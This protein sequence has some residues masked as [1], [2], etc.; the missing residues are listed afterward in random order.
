M[1]NPAVFIDRDGVIN[2]DHGYI[3]K[4]DDFEYI[5]GV[6][7]A[8][9]A[10][11]EMG[12]LL[13]LVTNQSGIARGYYTE[14]DFLTLTEWMDWNFADNGVDFDGIY[15]C[16]HHPEHGDETY[17]K[18]CDCRKPKPGMLLDASQFLKIDMDKSVMIGDKA[19]DMRAAEAAGVATKI[20]VRTGKQVSEEGE[21][22]ATAV[23]NSIA[24]VP[25]Y[26]KEM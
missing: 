11:K 6:F 4:V 21:A 5:D 20:L 19:D 1:A 12:Y 9:R 10:L 15:Y 23:L 13:V 17:K 26:L 16:P 8:C 18:D 24:D 14:D 22:L 7:D 3:S 25:A 2:V